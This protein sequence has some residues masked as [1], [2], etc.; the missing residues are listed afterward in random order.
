MSSVILKGGTSASLSGYDKELATLW[1]TTYR[2]LVDAQEA[3]GRRNPRGD[4]PDRRWN[5]LGGI[6]FLLVALGFLSI[7]L[8]Q[9]FI[10]AALF[11]TAVGALLGFFIARA[12]TPRQQTQQS[13]LFLA[14]VDGFRVVLGTDAAAARREF[15]QRSGL[16]AEAIFA[17]MLPMRP[18]PTMPSVLPSRSLP[19]TR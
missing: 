2:E 11:T 6:A 1:G 7:F 15:A 3:T 12:I 14:K 9:P 10:T 17:T 18:R 16:S 4:D 19:C 5:W 13:A 8:G